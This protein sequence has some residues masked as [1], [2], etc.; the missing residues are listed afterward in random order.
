MKK[1]AII[2]SL[3]IIGFSVTAFVAPKTSASA[4]F[5]GV[6]T[7]SMSIDN[8]QAASMMQ[9]SSV[10]VYMKGDKAKSVVDMTMQKITSIYDTKTPDEPIVLLEIM[11]NKYQVKNDPAKKKD[12]VAPTIKY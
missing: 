11:G 10:K 6:V 4:S 12:D 8:P 1:I 9:G 2:A 7:Y 5:E 3:A